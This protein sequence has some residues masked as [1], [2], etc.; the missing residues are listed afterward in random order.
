MLGYERRWRRRQAKSF[1][2]MTNFFKLP[3]WHFFAVSATRREAA[4]KQVIITSALSCF[5]LNKGAKNQNN[6]KFICRVF[7]K[8][9]VFSLKFCDF[10]ELCQFCCRAGVLSAWCVYTEGKQR[11]ARVQNN[12]KNSDKTQ[13]L[14]NTLWMSSGWWRTMLSVKETVQKALDNLPK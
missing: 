5:K 9:C 10:S 6:L 2:Q 8:Y 14:M 11:K 1:Q 7:I 13:Y 4:H 12:F 3:D